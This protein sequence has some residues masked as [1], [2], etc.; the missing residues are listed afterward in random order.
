MNVVL[1]FCFN[2]FIFSLSDGIN[3]NLTNDRTIYVASNGSETEDCGF[4]QKK[5]CKSI[6]SAVTMHKNISSI[7]I[8]NDNLYEDHILNKS[9][10]FLFFI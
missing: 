6:S 4:E 1:I 9:F 5:S 10:N 8:P 3:Y 7:R 2:I